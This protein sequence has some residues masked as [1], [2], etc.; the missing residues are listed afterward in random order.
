MSR[1]SNR[2]HIGVSVSSG[3]S[4]GLRALGRRGVGLPS[5]LWLLG[6]L[7]AGSLGLV[8]VPSVADAGSSRKVSGAQEGNCYTPLLSPDGSRVAYEVNFFERRVIELYV[9][10][11]VADTESQVTPKK[12]GP[13]SNLSAFNVQKRQVTYELSWQP[14]SPKKFIFASSGD[15]ENYNL[16]LSSGNVLA[17][18]PAADGQG[19]WSPDSRYIA[20]ASARSGEG[21]LYLIDISKVEEKPR[22]LTSFDDS[23]EWYPT[24]SPDARKLAFVR[25]LQRGGDNLYIIN[26]VDDPQKSLVAL[27]DWPSIQIKPSWSPDGKQVAFYSNRRS[28]ERYDV[29]V[30][31]AASNATPKL[32]LENVLPNE[33]LGPTWT[34]DGKALLVV[35]DDAERFNPIRV[36]S[37]VE[38]ARQKILATGTQNNSDIHLVK[39][40]D[41]KVRM[42]FTA[43]GRLGDNTK[44]FKRVYVYDPTSDELSP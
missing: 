4:A 42:A 11:L 43:Q 1:V 44:S 33:R 26:N 3:G 35:Q 5:R 22:Q 6:L 37:T 30:M 8:S 38:P 18:H 20:F 12:G 41:G 16:Y 24:F 31:D 28:K 10:D 21:D 39:L 7:A 13:S 34:P 36:I 29:Y 27:T 25:H 17:D 40:A 9:R 32:I 14:S 15:D 23:T 2:I 19:I